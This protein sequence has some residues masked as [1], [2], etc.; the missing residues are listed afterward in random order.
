MRESKKHYSKK[1]HSKK[2][3]SKKHHSKKHH[4]KKHSK[5][6]H[7]YRK[8]REILQIPGARGVPI[9]S[10]PDKNKNTPI[11]HNN[12]IKDE[13][14]MIPGLKNYLKNEK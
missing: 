5:R 3:H 11:L 7:L 2:H 14:E 6:K 8:R 10:S 12:N 13:V 4:S 1:H 9:F